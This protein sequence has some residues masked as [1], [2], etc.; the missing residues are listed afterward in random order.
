MGWELG[1][2]RSV[3]EFALPGA[4]P[5]AMITGA[6]MALLEALANAAVR[7]HRAV[8]ATEYPN[9]DALPESVRSRGDV[10]AGSAIR[11]VAIDGYDTATCCGTHVRNTA[12]L[13]AVK[14]VGTEHGR[15]GTV[16][17]LFLAGAR[18][19]AALAAGLERDRA[20]GKCFGCQP[21]DFVRRVEGLFE[22]T[23]ALT[24]AK[25]QLTAAL[26]ERDAARLVS[27]A[28][29]PAAPLVDLPAARLVASHCGG[30]A[31]DYLE[32]LVEQL[33]AHKDAFPE[34][35]LL[36]L[37][38][39]AEPKPAGPGCFLITLLNGTEQSCLLSALPFPLPL[40]CAFSSS[41]S[42]LAVLEQTS[43]RW[44][45]R[46]RLCSRARVA[47]RAARSRA[48]PPRWSISPSSLRL[49]L[50][51]LPL[52]PCDAFLFSLFSSSSSFFLRMTEGA[53]VPSKHDEVGTT[54]LARNCARVDYWCCPFGAHCVVTARF[55]R[56]V[57]TCREQDCALFRDGFVPCRRCATHLVAR[58]DAAT[59]AARCGTPCPADA[60]TPPSDESDK[61]RV[62]TLP[63]RCC[64]AAV[65]VDACRCAWCRLHQPFVLT[66]PADIA[67]LRPEYTRV[68]KSGEG[69]DEKEKDGDHKEE[70]QQQQPQPPQKR[71]RQERGDKTKE[72]DT[73]KDK[74]KGGEWGQWE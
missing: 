69:E 54:R 74:D 37:T 20:L 15:S 28:A 18:V 71:A 19:L 62:R 32:Q 56:H 38:A 57:A 29:Q 34:N 5:D 33:A 72:K 44:R 4:G 23:A 49:F 59:H 64:G 50:P 66:D 25:K 17:L 13:Q 30:A 12:D 60:A 11:V 7:Q 26:V 22:T 14:L 61:A 10:P 58:A 53:P 39:S 68:R 43:R 35:T 41:L 48:R 9:R 73:I 52:P 2:E 67:L 63:C 31:M 55:G 16:R 8:V 3:V 42:S 65:R 46:S 70:Q 21:A 36:L 6:E 27:A 1:T 45:R 40:P 24:R 47:A 51:P